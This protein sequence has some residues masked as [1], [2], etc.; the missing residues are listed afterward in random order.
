[1]NFISPY[2]LTG[3]LVLSLLAGFFGRRRMIGFWGFFFLSIMVT[4]LL[5]SFFL[6]VCTPVKAPR[7]AKPRVKAGV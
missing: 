3:Y 4:P 1:M 2:T 6:F 5:T 7:Q